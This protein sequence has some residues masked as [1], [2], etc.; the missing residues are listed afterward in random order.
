MAGAD[1]LATVHDYLN[2]FNHGD[3]DAMAAAF[4][5]PGTILDGMAPHLWHG[6]TAARDWYQAVLAEGK[7]HG[8]T[9][10]L[11]SRRSKSIYAV[12]LAIFRRV[13]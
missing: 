7:Q 3:A 6:P 13:P 2:A 9:E 5:E 11:C 10:Y 4:A 12:G 1:P 8:A